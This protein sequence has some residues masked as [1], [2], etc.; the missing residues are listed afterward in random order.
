MPYFYSLRRIAWLA[1]ALAVVLL[2]AIGVAEEAVPPWQLVQ[3]FL[4]W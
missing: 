1:F 4:A 2:L 3:R